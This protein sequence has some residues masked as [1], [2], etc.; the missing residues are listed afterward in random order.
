MATAAE[1][2]NKTS[3]DAQVVGSNALWV[4]VED[5]SI[6]QQVIQ[7]LFQLLRP[8]GFD[9]IHDVQVHDSI[10]TLQFASRLDQLIPVL[11]LLAHSCPCTFNV[12]G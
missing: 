2:L 10:F 7:T 8:H 11:H 1:K 12:G 4:Q 6:Q 9:L 5:G 3:L